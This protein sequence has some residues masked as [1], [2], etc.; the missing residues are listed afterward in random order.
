MEEGLVKVV[1]PIDDT[2]AFRAGIQAGDF[3]IEINGE[4][5]IGMS[6]GDAVD[7]M[8]GKI[9]PW[10]SFYFPFRAP[11]DHIFCPR[12]RTCAV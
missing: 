1:S 6:L 11:G 5:V 3:I 12:G 10:L 4:S 7:R 9:I 2:P 8:R